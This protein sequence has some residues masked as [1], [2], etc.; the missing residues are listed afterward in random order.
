MPTLF[1]SFT[2]ALST[3]FGSIDGHAKSGVPVFCGSAGSIT[4]RRNQH[5][6]EFYVH[7]FYG[8][9]GKQR[10][11]YVG[12]AEEAGRKIELLRQK[13]D[14]VKAILSEVRLLVRKGFQSADAKTYA[15]LASL[16]Q[17]GLFAA[18][19]SA[20]SL[21]D[22]LDPTPRYCSATKTLRY[23]AEP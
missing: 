1:Q 5:G 9:D 23:P 13:I 6:V 10:E 16:H 19:S 7:R 12:S 11:A 14:E 2:P 4:K 20:Q 21:A 18:E 17:H 15:T 3:L 22:F 8:G